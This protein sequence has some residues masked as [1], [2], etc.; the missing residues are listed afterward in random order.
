MRAKFTW[1]AELSHDG[2]DQCTRH[3]HLTVDETVQQKP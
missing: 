3:M 2:I 1:Y